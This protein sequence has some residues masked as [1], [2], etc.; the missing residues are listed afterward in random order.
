MPF[1]AKALSEYLKAFKDPAVIQASCEDYRSAATVDFEH[2][3]ADGNK[4]LKI[5][6]KV[7]WAEFG[8]IGCCF[9]PLKLWRLRAENVVGKSVKSQHYMAEEI[10]NEISELM[11][12]FF[13]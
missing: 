8:A 1:S 4:K 12:S 10:P 9:D 13:A 6:I 11:L 5:P 7:F 2:D 3:D